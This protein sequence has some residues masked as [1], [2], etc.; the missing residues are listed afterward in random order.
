MM[1]ESICVGNFYVNKLHQLQN[2]TEHLQEHLSSWRVLSSAAVQG[3]CD[4]D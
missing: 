2:F 3:L 4:S 1:V